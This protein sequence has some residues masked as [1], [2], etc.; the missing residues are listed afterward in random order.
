MIEDAW[1]SRLL[2]DLAFSWKSGK[3]LR[4]FKTLLI[5]EILLSE[6]SLSPN[7]YYFNLCEFLKQWIHAFVEKLKNRCFCWFRWPYL[8]PSKGTLTWHLH[9]KLSKLIILGKRFFR[10]SCM[11]NI[12][13]TWFFTLGEAFC[14][15]IFFHFPDS[16]LSVLNG[17]HFYF[18]WRDSENRE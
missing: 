12:A 1:I 18:W 14:V 7:K 16:G 3:I 13:Q 4:V 11:W 2:H 15:F 9:T 8:R 6:H 17:L 10:I 5:F